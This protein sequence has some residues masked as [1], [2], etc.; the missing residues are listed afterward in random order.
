MARE[1]R[2]GC[3]WRKADCLAA[4]FLLVAATAH[5]KAQ[6]ENYA[7]ISLDTTQDLCPVTPTQARSR[8]NVFGTFMK[9]PQILEAA[10]SQ[11]S[12]Q[13][14][15]M[16]SENLA[17]PAGSVHFRRSNV[18][19]NDSVSLSIAWMKDETIEY[20]SDFTTWQN[21]IERA[22]RYAIDQGICIPHKLQF[23]LPKLRPGRYRVALPRGQDG[24][25]HPVIQI[26]YNFVPTAENSPSIANS[27]ELDRRFD[28]LPAH[29]RPFDAATKTIL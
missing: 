22:I 25:A 2:Y 18:R 28:N 4:I 27:V 14:A 20:Q 12:S 8:W 1:K 17:N 26:P 6:S 11:H 3:F 15:Y 5:A 29:T 7:I 9:L 24:A 10:T 21:A 23:A 19:I 16:P 13:L